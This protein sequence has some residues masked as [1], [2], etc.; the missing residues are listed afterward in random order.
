MVLEVYTKP[1][2]SLCD[3][4]LELI[5]QLRERHPFELVLHNIFERQ[6]WFDAHRQRIPVVAIDGV[7][8][9]QLRFTFAQL[10]AAFDEHRKKPT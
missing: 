3:D 5:D 9:L 1:G 8:V 7:E 4:M 2:C 10:Q 6:E